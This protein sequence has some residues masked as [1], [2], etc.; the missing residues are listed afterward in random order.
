MDVQ[1]LVVEDETLVRKTL[2][3]KL[4]KEGYSSAEAKNGTQARELLPSRLWDLVLLDI[5]LPDANGL[6]LLEEIHRHDPDLPVIMLTGNQA[7]ETVVRAMKLGATNYV[8]KPFN[9]EEL[10]WTIKTA[11][12]VTEMQRQLR[13]LRFNAFKNNGFERIVGKSKILKKVIHLAEVVAESQAETVLILG[14]SGTGKNLLARAIHSKSIRADKPFLEVT[15]TALSENLLESELFGH[16]RGSFTDARS[17]KKGLCELAHCGS[18]FLDEIGDL[19]MPI[20]AKLLGFLES[21]KF[22]R[23]GGTRDIAVNLR[24][25]AATN[26][27]LDEKIR[28]NRFREDLYYRLNVIEITMPSLRQRPEDIPILAQFFVDNFNRKF[29]KQVAG[30]QDSAMALLND[31]PWPGNVRELRNLIER[32]MILTTSNQLTEDD[33]PLKKVAVSKTNPLPVELPE[34]GTD[35]DQ[36]EESLVRQALKRT[37]GNQTKAARLLHL[38]RDQLRYRMKQYDL[39]SK[40]S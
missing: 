6:D 38:S 5:R 18:L 22:R 20:Q 3:R 28:Q 19:P 26:S 40:E 23:V 12:N 24:V 34:Q 35:L 25:I 29:R 9:L 10:A 33:L 8:T 36:I 2:V 31:Y 39:F 13:S 32:A 21:R 15:C 7:T 11:L 16:E 30:I 27:R 17:Q 37:G 4:A 1:I 14:E